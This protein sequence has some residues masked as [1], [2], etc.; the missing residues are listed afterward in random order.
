MTLL[1]AEPNVVE[2][3]AGAKFSFHVCVVK[4]AGISSVHGDLE[5][6]CSEVIELD[7]AGLSVPLAP[8]DHQ[9]IMTIS[10]AHA[11][12]LRVQGVDLTYRDGLQ[13]GTQRVGE[14]VWLRFT[15]A[16]QPR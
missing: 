11:G 13:E 2:N 14:Y 3:T 4:G 5:R 10:A 8:K 6:W 1:E 9:L 15:R 16:V 12:E 7:D